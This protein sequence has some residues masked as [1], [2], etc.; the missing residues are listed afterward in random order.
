MGGIQWQ[1]LTAC[2]THH[3]RI[4]TI[5]VSNYSIYTDK[6]LISFA[7]RKRVSLRPSWACESMCSLSIILLNPRDRD[8]QQKILM[9]D[10]LS[11]TVEIELGHVGTKSQNQVWVQDKSSLIL[12]N[13]NTGK[14]NKKYIS[15]YK[16]GNVLKKKWKAYEG[17]TEMKIHR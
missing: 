1:H 8:R 3:L 15:L 7:G 12:S 4:S 9:P 2:E 17:S 16:S 6:G 5:G 10:Q 13:I 11:E 14:K